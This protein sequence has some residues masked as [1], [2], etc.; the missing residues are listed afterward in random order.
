MNQHTKKAGAIAVILGSIVAGGRALQRPF[1][2]A[3]R[4]AVHSSG[5]VHGL[6]GAAGHSSGMIRGTE[7]A[8]GMG[9]SPGAVRSTES[10]LG[11][12]GRWTP[13]TEHPD[14]H[15]SEFARRF[16]APASGRALREEADKEARTAWPPFHPLP[17]VWS[18]N[19]A[20]TQQNQPPP[21]D[22]DDRE[23]E[24]RAKEIEQMIK[25]SAK[26]AQGIK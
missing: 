1:R 24:K 11:H 2:A 18:R 17:R 9:H 14:L 10:V 22:A 19:H 16:E 20:D 15:P 12:P 6:E 21:G 23:R 26:P 25:R 7:N 4:P 13:A 5:M 3:A 8:L